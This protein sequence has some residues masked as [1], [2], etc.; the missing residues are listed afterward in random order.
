[1]VLRAAFVSIILLT[2]AP[3]AR[4]EDC[5]QY[6]PGPM[7]FDCASRNNPRAGE[8]LERCRAEAMQ[9]GLKPRGGAG[10]GGGGMKPYVQACMQRR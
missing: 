7:R 6:P 8:K 9:M 4:A 2:A 10:G 1:M 5:R 3:S